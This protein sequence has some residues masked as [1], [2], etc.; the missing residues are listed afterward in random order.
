MFAVY[1]RHRQNTGKEA[2]EE[3]KWRIIVKAQDII[4]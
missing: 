1:H 3:E 2:E 4:R